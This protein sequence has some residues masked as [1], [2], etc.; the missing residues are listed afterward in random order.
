METKIL[1]QGQIVVIND[2]ILKM[3]E[4]GQHTIAEIERKSREDDARREAELELKKNQ[5]MM[6]FATQV[7]QLFPGLMGYAAIEDAFR[8][9]EDWD[10]HLCLPVRIPGFA[11]ISMGFG[12]KP[13]FQFEYAKWALVE[14]FQPDEEEMGWEIFE[15]VQPK[16]TFRDSRDVSNFEIV[17]ARA[18]EEGQMMALESVK[19][20]T[21]KA[22]LIR[23]R[24][25]YHQ[26]VAEEEKRHRMIEELAA[27]EEPT[28]T[29]Q[30]RVFL[31]AVYDFL[32]WR[33]QAA[34]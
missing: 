30:E 32:E 8:N 18:Q 13:K 26:K 10:T 3:L 20:E 4:R 19:W 11:P 16:F 33:D 29:V 34:E 21:V 7:D 31:D 15:H 1:E 23:E 28:C 9:W 25:I 27:Q 2:N 14:F 5:A 6:V 17:L 24:E 12:I 22:D